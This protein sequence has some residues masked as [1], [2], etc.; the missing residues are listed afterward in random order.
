[1]ADDMSFQQLCVLVQ[2]MVV[3]RSTDTV[4]LYSNMPCK[5]SE[6]ISKFHQVATPTY[7]TT[8]TCWSVS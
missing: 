3:Q 5:Y 6:L 1:M 4:A 7:K 2:I 8:W